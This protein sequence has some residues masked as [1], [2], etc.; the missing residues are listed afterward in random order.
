M[1]A[2]FRLV[3]ACLSV[4]LLSSLPA[5]ARQAAQAP[6]PRDVVYAALRGATLSGEAATVSNLVLKRDAATFTLRSGTL[7]FLAPVEGR[8]T[9]AVFVG[10][11]EFT[12]TPPEEHER[13]SL[14]VFTKSQTVTEKVTALVLRFTDDTYDEVKR[15]ATVATGAAGADQAADIWRESAATAAGTLRE[16]YPLRVLRD[17]YSGR[18]GGYFA[19]FIK[20]E[21]WG[22]LLFKLDPHEPE[23]VSL[24]SWGDTDGGIWTSFRSG[25]ASSHADLSIQEQVLFDIVQ[26]DISLAIDGKRM[27]G[28]DLVTLKPARDGVRVLPFSLDP[29]LRVTKVTGADGSTM[30]FVQ[31]RK[32][33]DGDFA[34]LLPAVAPAGADLKLTIE[35]G[36]D[37]TLADEGGGNFFLESRSSWYPNNSVVPFGDKARFRM[38]FV[39]PSGNQLVATGELA[40]PETQEGKLTVA[41]WTSGDVDLKVAG[42][43]YGKF[44]VKGLKDADTGYTIE[45]YA[46]KELPSWLRSAED[47]G[48]GMISTLGMADAAI[49]EAQNST[50]IFN[51]YFGKLPY[52]KITMSQQ[53]AP[54]FGQSWPTLIYMPIFTYLD[55]TTR[56]RLMGIRGGTDEFW[57]YV[58]PHEVAHQ[59]WG[60]IVGWSTYRDQWISEGFA[61]FSASLYVQHAVGFDKFKEF[62]EDERKMITTATPATNGKAPYTIGPVTQGYRLNGAK[63]GNVARNIIYPKGAYILHMVR[64]MM[65][66]WGTT[67]DEKFK[68]MMKDFV[69]TNWNGD[70]TTEDFKRAVEKHMTPAMDISKNGKMD[71]FFDEWVYGTEMPSY[72]L[73]YSFRDQGG[74]T[75]FS[76]KVTQSGVSDKFAMLV[77]LYV[78]FGKGPVRLGS[79]RLAGNTTQPFEMPLPQK[80][81]SASLN[82]LHDVLYLKSEA[83]Q[84]K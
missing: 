15:H 14:E 32:D 10:D 84:T 11:G 56:V 21:R 73:E 23:Q 41:K 62:W 59:W 66:E 17:V 34:V 52:A 55:S 43:N 53:P 58:G 16:N 64:M 12:I 3:S 19:A 70:V 54:N 80:P 75:I 2:R 45:V 25:G 22:K 33:Q 82:A 26:H 18:P 65:Y 57:K 35:Y 1:N 29:R 83:S 51:E 6:A 9:G 24:T 68:A 30:Q 37:E 40:E 13:R 31:E 71:W 61:E 76:G 49:A 36:G 67:K 42:F 20:G 46:N 28:T 74:Q 72:K 44:K 69:Q 48:G 63:T 47:D 39:Y 7:F 78:D 38:R 8:V 60:H 79:F 4:S 50:R 77:P 81:K 5:S 27:T